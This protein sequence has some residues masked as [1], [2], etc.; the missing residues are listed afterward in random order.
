MDK[1]RTL[2][3]VIATSMLIL[4]GP[5]GAARAAQDA[6]TLFRTKCSSCHTFGK[7][8]RVG[9]D[10]KGVSG[11]HPRPWL[12]AWIRS[13]ESQIRLGDP[14]AEALFRKYR[15]QRMPDH[16]LSDAQVA[17]LL[18]YIDAGGPA[19]DE[20][21][22]MRLAIDATP[23]DVQLG[24][25]LFFGEAR[26]AGSA[27]ACVFCHQ[28]SKQTRLGGSLA[29]DLSV[30]YTR[31]LDWALD[32]RLR[33]PCVRGSTDPNAARVA[34]AESLALR[35]FLRAVSTDFRPNSINDRG[36]AGIRTPASR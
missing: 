34:D 5:V 11:R 29:P 35:A 16:D 25:R 30:A 26:L 21:E 18:D 12:I 9:P 28:L 10:L 19:A 24:R 22:H 27:V 13:S 32:Q 20:G 31:Y 3:T 1:Q 8:D 23:Q 14:V 36:S 6:S 33:R 4:F 7:G 15:Q 2:V 17:A